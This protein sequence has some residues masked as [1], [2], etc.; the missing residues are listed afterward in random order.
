MADRVFKSSYAYVKVPDRAGAGANVLSA[1]KRAKVNMRAYQGFPAGG[2]QAQLDIVPQSMAAL[3]RVA[4]KEGW[5]LS[6]PKPCLLVLGKDRVGAVDATIG[7]LGKAGISVTAASAANAGRGAYG[8]VLWVKPRSF[9]R[10]A[11]LLGARR[12]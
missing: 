1:L 5:K 4:K 2:G 9:T 11:K 10:A 7:K 12:G 3:K 6:K 8:M